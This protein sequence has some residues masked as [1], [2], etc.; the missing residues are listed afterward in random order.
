MAMYV[1]LKGELPPIFLPAGPPTPVGEALAMASQMWRKDP[2][3]ARLLFQGRPLEDLSKPLAEYGVGPD[4][5][6]ELEVVE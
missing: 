1:R 5:L 6:L 3:K 2:T 4:D